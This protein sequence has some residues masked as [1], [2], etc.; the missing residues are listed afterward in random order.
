[1]NGN[2]GENSGNRPTP[3]SALVHGLHSRGALPHLK[4]EGASY[5]VTFRLAGTLPRE[6]L[7]RLKR[8]R[9][10]IIRTAQAHN[11]PLTW[12]EQ[13]E[14]FEWYSRKV[15]QHLDDGHGDCWLRREEIARLVASALQYF[16]GER[17]TLGAWV[18]MPTHVHTVVRPESEWTLSRILKSWKSFTALEANKLLGRTGLPFWQSESYDHCCRDNADFARCVRY[19]LMNPVH[20]GLCDTPESWVWSSAWRGEPRWRG[21]HGAA[22]VGQTKGQTKGQTVGQTVGQT[23]GLPVKKPPAS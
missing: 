13:N 10:N 6:V 20:A 1:M 21:F 17:Y 3:S 19:S 14:L 22:L 11:R 12:Q 7:V 8:E 16:A 5:F 15:D 18:I 4:R 9:E 2:C 23:S